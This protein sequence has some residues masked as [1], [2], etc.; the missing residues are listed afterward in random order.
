MDDCE[1]GTERPIGSGAAA[2]GRGGRMSRQGKTAA[3]LRGEELEMVSRALEVTAATLTRW[4]DGFLG[5]GEAALATQPGSGEVLENERLKAKLGEVMV[6]R[7]LLHEKIAILEAGRPLARRRLRPGHEGR[8]RGGHGPSLWPRR[9]LPGLGAC[10]ASRFAGTG[11]RRSLT[12]ALDRS[13][14]WRT[15]HWSPL[16]APCW[17][18]TSFTAKGIARSGRGCASVACAPPD[19]GCC[20]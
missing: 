5:A 13:E 14:R 8:R 11:V 1:A 17:P 3:V 9:G 15:R 18:T 6:E 19:V 7:E 12:G 4:R 2:P 20:G 16:S 10:H